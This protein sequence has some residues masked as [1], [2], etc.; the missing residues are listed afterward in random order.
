[1]PGPSQVGRLGGC[2]CGA[3]GEQSGSSGPLG[4]QWG[5]STAVD[6][7]ETQK[8]VDQISIIKGSI[9]SLAAW[10][11]CGL[12]ARGDGP[13]LHPCDCLLKQALAERLMMGNISFLSVHFCRLIVL[14]YIVKALTLTN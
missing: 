14:S 3:C 2:Y 1:M 9:P 7:F 5:P 12:A 10:R 8:C 4:L 6:W 13:R 11:L